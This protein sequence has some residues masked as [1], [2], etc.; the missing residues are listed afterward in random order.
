LASNSTTSQR[1]KN[2]STNPAWKTFI[3][4][5]DTAIHITYWKFIAKHNSSKAYHHPLQ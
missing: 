2:N 5:H 1:L 4:N 3:L